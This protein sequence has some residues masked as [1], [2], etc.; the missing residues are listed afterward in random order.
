MR[1]AHGF[2][3]RRV[4]CWGRRMRMKRLLFTQPTRFLPF[5]SD[6][7]FPASL[8][9]V[10]LPLL[11]PF[12]TPFL[13]GFVLLRAQ[14][15][16][17]WLERGGPLDVAKS[18][19]SIALKVKRGGRCTSTAHGKTVIIILFWITW[20]WWA[21]WRQEGDCF[22][23]H[24]NG[25]MMKLWIAENGG[26]ALFAGHLKITR[27]CNENWVQ[28]LQQTQIKCRREGRFNLYAMLPP[29]HVESTSI[30]SFP[31]SIQ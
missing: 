25:E 23:P 14:S 27:C 8:H 5:H 17:V 3:T 6:L 4:V 11:F 31:D 9:V 19:P 22:V 2:P 13:A 7:F 20:R 28:R 21:L 1:V 26:N 30:F 12:R 18:S 15:V 16:Y 10:V 24:A 29:P